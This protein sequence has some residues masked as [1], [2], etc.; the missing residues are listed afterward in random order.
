MIEL[1]NAKELVKALKGSSNLIMAMKRAGYRFQYQAIRRTTLQHALAALEG[2]PEFV[3]DHYVRK[4]WE[5]LPQ[6]LAPKE[7]STP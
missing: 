1:L 2:A 6:L 4:G 5:K 7:R 3:A